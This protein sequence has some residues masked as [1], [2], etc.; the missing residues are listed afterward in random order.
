M[1]INKIMS[2]VFSVTIVWM[3][4]VEVRGGVVSPKNVRKGGGLAALKKEEKRGA[5]RDNI[6]TRTLAQIVSPANT[7]PD[8]FTQ[9]EAHLYLQPIRKLIDKN[10]PHTEA[11]LDVVA[12][13]IANEAEHKDTH[14][15]FYNTTSNVWRLAQDLY[16]RL[17]AYENPGA[18]SKDFKFLRFNDESV[19]STAQ[20]FLVNELKEKGLVDDNTETGAIMVSVNLSLFGNVGFPGECSWEYFIHPQGHKE[21]KRETYEKMMDRFGMSHKYI[22]ELMSLVKIYDTKEDTIVQILVPI[23]KIDDIGYL[24]WVKGIPAHGATISWVLKHAKNKQFAHTAPTL[25]KLKE[26]FAK[27]Q[28]KNKLFEDMLADV[29]AGEFSLASFLKGYRNKPWD[30]EHINDVTAR[31]L[32]TPDVLLNPQSGVKFFRFSTVSN[33]KLREY[34]ARLNSIINKMIAEK[35]SG[36]GAKRVPNAPQKLGRAQAR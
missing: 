4:V 18:T 14:Y 25:D 13:V 34:N 27:Q 23:E 11:H 31:L 24:A 6:D 29:Q 2:I 21:P 1:K 28:G 35:Q 17:Y 30:I 8:R 26:R 7:K 19:N 12:T 22:N 3:N 33:D 16:T 5:K 9:T 32:F 20:S 10:Y 15:A 36:Q